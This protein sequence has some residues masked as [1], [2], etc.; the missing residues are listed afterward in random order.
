MQPNNILQTQSS[1]QELRL[2]PQRGLYFMS[3]PIGAGFVLHCTR[4]HLGE[5][6]FHFYVPL[7]LC[8]ESGCQKELNIITTIISPLSEP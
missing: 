1:N 3:R 8:D 7:P 5:R 6:T 2:F 4:R